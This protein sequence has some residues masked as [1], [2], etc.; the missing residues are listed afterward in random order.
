MNSLH[1]YSLRSTDHSSLNDSAMNM[2]GINDTMIMHLPTDMLIAFITI[3]LLAFLGLTINTIL[4]ILMSYS[5]HTK[6]AA[7]GLV[8]HLA[9]CDLLTTIPTL[10]YCPIILA[11]NGIGWP[12]HILSRLCKGVIFCLTTFYSVNV[13]TLTLMSIERYRA[14]IHPMKPR[15]S[16]PKMAV[17]VIFLWLS[18][19]IVPAIGISNTEADLRTRYLCVLHGAHQ[20]FVVILNFSYYVVVGYIIPACIMSYCYKMIIKKL[21]QTSLAN[22]NNLR[23]ESKREFQ[24]NLAVK[25]LIA[26]SIVFILTG[27]PLVI[28]LIIHI[29]MDTKLS[30]LTHNDRNIINSCTILF[31]ILLQFA[32]LYNPMIHLAKKKNFW[33]TLYSKNNRVLPISH[34]TSPTSCYGLKI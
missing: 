23:I 26:V 1:V 12:I 17:L 6:T 10:I 27:I 7:D 2:S 13:G 31:W 3:T 5:K 29:Y 22:K 16:G 4:I 15:I 32:P 34:S 9:I 33:H 21:K 11:F 30:H 8:I 24:K 20:H 14:I 25:I 28:G 19:I 18:V